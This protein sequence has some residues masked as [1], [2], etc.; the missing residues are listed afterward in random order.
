MPLLD[1]DAAADDDDRDLAEEHSSSES[2][3]SEGTK[4]FLS[5]SAFLWYFLFVSR[6]NQKF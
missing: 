4:S 3:I 5:I 1:E 2:A 6:D